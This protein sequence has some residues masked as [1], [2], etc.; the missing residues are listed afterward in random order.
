MPLGID[1]KVDFAFKLMLGNPDHPAVTI[2]FLNAILKPSVPVAEVTILNPI[3]GKDRSEEKLVILD[4]LA[5]DAHGRLFN[6]EMQTTRHV[7]L[8]R[9]LLYYGALGYARQIGEGQ[10]YRDLRPVHSICVMDDVLFPAASYPRYHHSFRLRCDQLD[11][12]FTD[13]L[14]FHTLELPKFVP[15]EDNIRKLSAEEKWLYLLINADTMDSDELRDLLVDPPYREAIGILEMISKSPEDLQFYEARLKF[16]R[17]KQS[18]IEAAEQA[19]HDAREEGLERGDLRGTIR[20]LQ[21]VLGEQVSSNEQ[22]DALRLSELKTLIA[23]L[24]G[25]LGNH[26]S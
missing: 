25:R 3:Q 19:V 2:H 15:S 8:Q 17:D 26:N 12:V 10:T 24:Q 14:E 1:P 11:L 21:T 4:I 7:D 22:L 6:V 23:S 9:R 5:Q 20:T 16:L 13:D 18:Q